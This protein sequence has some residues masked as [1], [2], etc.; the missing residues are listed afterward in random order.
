M[1]DT[2]SLLSS[3]Q[4]LFERS[5]EAEKIR[6]LTI[7]PDEWG[8]LTIQKWFK[9]SDHQARLALI[10]KKD[11]GLLSY[12]EYLHGNKP[13]NEELIDAVQRFYLQDGISRSSPRKKDM[14]QINRMPVPVRFMQMSVGEAH[15]QFLADFPMMLIG[16]SS[17]YALRPRQVKLNGP[18]DTCLCI[19]HENIFLLLKVCGEHL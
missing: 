15:Q 3:L 7:A 1:K 5:S 16:K 14:I 12:P 17:F 2:T 6:L 18:S 8:R 9:C 10:V 13:L 19:Y 4:L 11:H